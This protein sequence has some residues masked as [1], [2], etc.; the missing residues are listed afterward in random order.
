MFTKTDTIFIDR[1]VLKKFGP[2]WSFHECVS[3]CDSYYVILSHV[4]FFHRVDSDRLVKVADF[5]LA[6][7]IYEKEYYRI[8]DKTRPL[9]VKWM[10]LEAIEAQKFTTKSD[11]V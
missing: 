8:E 1:H 6:R 11:V 3:P 9:P 5:G 7:D 4:S 10:A 2:V